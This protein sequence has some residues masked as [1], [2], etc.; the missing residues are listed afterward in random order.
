MH[1]GPNVKYTDGN[2]FSSTDNPRNRLTSR[3]RHFVQHYDLVISPKTIVLEQEA[4]PDVKLPQCQGEMDKE[5]IATTS[6]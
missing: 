6:V 3:F 2:T 5:Y 4:A 1:W